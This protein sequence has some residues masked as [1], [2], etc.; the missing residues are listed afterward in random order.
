MLYFYPNKP[1]LINP[2]NQIVL[3]KSVD[4]N[5]SAEIKKNG[6]RLC[7]WKSKTDSLKH[8]NYNNFIFWNR[9][10]SVLKYEPSKELLDELNSFDIPDNTHIDAELLHFKTHDTKHKIYIYD[11]YRFNGEQIFQKLSLRRKIL[12]YIF[13]H[14]TEHIQVAPVYKG[15]DFKALYDEV[16]KESINEGLVLKDEN[17]EIVWNLKDCP[18]VSWQFK[19]RKETKNYQF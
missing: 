14:E 7:L 15:Q 12:N 10:K 17:G 11:I 6:T 9:H 13:K 1:V 18:E 19:I 16:T 5:W 8:V 4:P 3:D 2:E